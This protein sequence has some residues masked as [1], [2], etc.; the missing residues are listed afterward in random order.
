MQPHVNVVTA[1]GDC[2]GEAKVVGRAVPRKRKVKSRR[3]LQRVLIDPTGPYPPSRASSVGEIP[4]WGGGAVVDAAA[5]AVAVAPVATT[6]TGSGV[7]PAAS[8]RGAEGAPVSAALAATTVT[9]SRVFPAASVREAAGVPASA[10]VA[11]HRRRQRRF[12]R[13]GRGRRRQREA[14]CSP[15]LR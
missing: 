3:P 6:V 10:A 4:T 2:C 12:H 15:R 11:K 7:F 8:A 5:A 9:G 14:L 13:I 1:S